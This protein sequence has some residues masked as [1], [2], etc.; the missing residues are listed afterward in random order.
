M[1]ALEIPDNAGKQDDG[2]FHEEVALLLHPRFIEVE[3]NG[4]GT[5]IGIRNVLHEVRMNGITAV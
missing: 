3:H 2:R 1:G 5:F 4:I